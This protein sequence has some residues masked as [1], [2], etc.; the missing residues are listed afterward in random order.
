[1]LYK[2]INPSDTIT[3]IASDHKLAFAAAV[4]LGSGKVGVRCVDHPDATIPAL[5]AFSPK[6]IK[7][8]E[9]YLG[10][11]INIF[12]NKNAEAMAV[13]YE[14]FAYVSIEGRRM[15]DAACAAITDQEKLAE[16]KAKIEDE[17]RTSM[18]RWVL[19]AWK[20]AEYF[21]ELSNKKNPHRGYIVYNYES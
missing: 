15:Y 20:Y 12:I 18:S 7:I 11:N 19:A 4:Y 2:L 8:I 3:F 5:C 1:M 10:D 16:F 21:K 6:P 9:E 14:S 17:R 13:C